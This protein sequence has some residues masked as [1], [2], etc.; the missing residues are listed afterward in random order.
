[1]VKAGSAAAIIDASGNI[2]TITNGGLV[3]TNG[4]ADATTANVIELAYVN[5]TIWQ[6]N[7]SKLWWGETQPNTGW[8]IGA[9]TATSPLPATSG[10]T[11]PPT[12]TVIGSGSDTIV[13]TM[14]EDADGPVGAAG[15]DAE[16]TLNVDGQ[17]IG[18]LQTVTASH[19]AGQTQTF[20]FQGNFTPGQHALTVTFANN[21][22]TAGDKAA[23]NDGGDRNV[24]VNSVTYDGTS[25]S[26]TVTP[27]YVSAFYPPL[28]TTGFYP[29]NAVFTA[30]DTTSIPA[31]APSTP[32][33]TPAAV[34]A[35][36]GADT[37]T[38]AM[39]EDPYM[40]DAQFTVSVDGKQVGG[41]FTTSAISW[42]GQTQQFTL[43]GSWGNGPHTVAVTFLN[44]LIGPPDSA[45]AYDPV[46]RNLYIN[47]ISYDGTAVAGTPWGLFND[48]S[49]TFNMPATAVPSPPPSA[50]SPNDTMVL[51]GSTGAITDGS[52]NR[53]TITSTGQ[54]AV[55]GVADPT[56]GNVTELAYVNN[57]VWQE[58]SSALWWSKTNP[59]ASW[60][61]GTGTA[62][63]PLPAPIT[64][65][66]SPTSATVSQS[67]ISVIATAGNH[68]LFIKGIGDVLSLSGGT[69]LITD[70]GG[71]NTYILPTAGKGIDKFTSDI[72]TNGDTLDLHNAL[73]G[74]KWTG[75]SNT[76]ASFLAV[77]DS[78]QGAIVSVVAT[79]GGT[80][81]VIATIAGATTAKL[82]DLMAH[83]F[84]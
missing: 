14:S 77:A 70:T 74:T 45:G 80:Q 8:A 13:L 7:S 41:T 1:M 78:A 55:N 61:P 35:G 73:A 37:L 20:T 42:E 84:T 33:T 44:D 43:K 12:G 52:A 82:S 38:L 67:E 75:S 63:S 5:G 39:S 47:A 65:A 11:P 30:T 81:S 2:W 29:G 49:Q 9:G 51:A 31:N 15:R 57:A 48:G 19:G 23:F 72:F 21:S 27:I 6:E 32:T 60:T 59:S 68:T 46:D 58:N 69:N 3:A 34:Q 4:N 62:T 10:P 54:V 76:L 18:G 56:T 16:F 66:A 28:S 50:A 83:S 40:G 17:Q 79:P 64:I 71:K 22:M 24:Y 26:S 36:T 25:V 53:W